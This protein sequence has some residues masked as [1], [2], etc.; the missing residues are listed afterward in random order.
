MFRDA[1]A[2]RIVRSDAKIPSTLG[3]GS[4]EVNPRGRREILIAKRFAIRNCSVLCFLVF[5]LN[6]NIFE[7]ISAAINHADL[8]GVRMRVAGE[9]R[10]A[11]SKD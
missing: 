7:G 5:T 3:D 8:R 11:K 10:T 9:R 2:I 1:S 6:S 4:R